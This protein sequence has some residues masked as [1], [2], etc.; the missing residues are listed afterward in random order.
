MWMEDYVG[1]VSFSYC[2]YTPAEG[3]VSY[4][5]PYLISL[6]FTSSFTKFLFNLQTIKEPTS[7][8]EACLYPEWIKAMETEL[9][10]L[11]ENTT[12]VITS[13]P[14]GK[15]PIGSKWVYKW[16]SC[17]PSLGGQCG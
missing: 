1:N 10:A 2:I 15:R 13:L 11:E 12:W 6:G 5:F 4:T 7:Y 17:T 14:E 16:R 3:S 8:K 9:T